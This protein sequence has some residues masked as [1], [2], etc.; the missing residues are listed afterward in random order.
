MSAAKLNEHGEQ[1]AVLKVEIEHVRQEVRRNREENDAHAKATMLALEALKTDM[2]ER[3][4]AEKLASALRMIFASTIGA[5]IMK[6]I[7]WFGAL[8]K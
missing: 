2:N 8:P 3:K 7:A 1:L 6:A 5:F 4:G